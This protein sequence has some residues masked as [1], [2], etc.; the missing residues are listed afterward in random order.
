MRVC[1]Y[2]KYVYLRQYNNTT[3]LYLLVLKLFFKYTKTPPSIECQA[4][5]FIYNEMFVQISEI[6]KKYQNGVKLHPCGVK[7]TT[8]L[9]FST[10]R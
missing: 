7:L 6:T 1:V 9:K 5:W 4:C 3:I 8:D 2:N 10:F